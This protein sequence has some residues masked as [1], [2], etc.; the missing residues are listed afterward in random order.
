MHYASICVA[1]R[2]THIVATRT[3]QLNAELDEERSQRELSSV[4]CFVA[5]VNVAASVVTFPSPRAVGL[6]GALEIPS[7]IGKTSSPCGAKVGSDY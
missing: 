4:K 2:F 3:G 7:I 6:G 1:R 5:T